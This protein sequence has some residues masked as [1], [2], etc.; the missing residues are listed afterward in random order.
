MEDEGFAKVFG[1]QDLLFECLNLEGQG[2]FMKM[3][4]AGLADGHDAVLVEHG[5]QQS[6]LLLQELSFGMFVEPPRVDS[7][8]L[9]EAYGFRS[10]CG[11]GVVCVDIDK[12]SNHAQNLRQRYQNFAIYFLLLQRQNHR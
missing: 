11:N 1:E 7:V 4:D 2:V 10:R 5:F 12:W 3:V 8:A 6:Q 9:E